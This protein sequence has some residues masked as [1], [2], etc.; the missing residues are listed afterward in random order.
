MKRFIFSAAV[1]ALFAMQTSANASLEMINFES[2]STGFV[3]NGFVSNDSSLV[4]FTDSMGAEL[5]IS[6]FGNQSDGNALAVRGDDSSF[7]IMDFTTLV[8]SLSLDF[9]NDDPGFSNA[10]DNA[11]L[12]LFNG[13]TQVGQ[14]S[15]E[16]NRNDLMDQTISFSGAQFDRAEFLYD[17]TTNGLIEIVDNIQFETATALVPEPGSVVIWSVFALSGMAIRRRRS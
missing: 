6:N 3:P 17:V 16:M 7:L 8:E 9:G 4:S 1:L 13:A 11:V 10:G 2:D 15:V 14:V 12:T 5:E